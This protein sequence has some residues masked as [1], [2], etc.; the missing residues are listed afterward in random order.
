MLRSFKLRVSPVLIKLGT[1]GIRR[2][3]ELH[4]SVQAERVVAKL[5]ADVTLRKTEEYTTWL[6]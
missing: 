4:P 1:V 6:S 2:Y 5:I 3:D